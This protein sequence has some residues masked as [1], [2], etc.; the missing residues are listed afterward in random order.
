[1]DD[2]RLVVV[3]LNII[4]MVKSKRLREAGHVA[5]MVKN[6]NAYGL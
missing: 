4:R 6:R 2:G 1:M 5:R 3:V